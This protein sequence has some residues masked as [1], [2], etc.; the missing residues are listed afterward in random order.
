MTV[1]TDKQIKKLVRA[2]EEL[3]HRQRALDIEVN[4]FARELRA[5]FPVMAAEVRWGCWHPVDARIVVSGATAAED[6]IVCGECHSDLG[7][8]HGSLSRTSDCDLK[9]TI[10]VERETDGR[11]IA[12]VEEL[13]GVIIYN[14]TKDLAVAAV[15]ALALRVLSEKLERAAVNWKS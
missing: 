2:W 10:E 9:F 8:R 7:T 6:R 3:C 5:Q 14:A 4:A 11:W 15:K 1:M 13:P 12:A